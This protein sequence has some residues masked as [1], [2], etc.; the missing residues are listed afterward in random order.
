MILILVVIEL[1]FFILFFRFNNP[2]I[3]FK[4]DAFFI[5]LIVQVFAYTVL[6]PSALAMDFPDILKSEYI[7]NI[8]FSF[9]FFIIPLCL[10]YA[11]LR[12]VRFN[13][14]NI[15]V[16]SKNAQLTEGARIKNLFP[17]C[18]VWL[19]FEGMYLYF[20]CKNHLFY[21]RVGTEVIAQRLA[22]IPHV[23]LF[24]IRSVELIA[25]PVIALLWI[26]L[27]KTRL[28]ISLSALQKKIVMFTL[29]VSFFAYAMTSLLNSRALF[30]ELFIFM[31]L[32]YFTFKSINL[33]KF[34]KQGIILLL[35]IVYLIFIIANLRVYDK[36]KDS[37]LDL[38]NV[39]YSFKKS[40]ES[41]AKLQWLS[42]MDCM[43]LITK[44]QPALENS[45]YAY[46]EAW[47]T[48]FLIAVGQF[49]SPSLVHQAKSQA[50]T[51]AKVYL[52]E[53]YTQ[54][55]SKD[56]QS[57]SLTDVY[58]NF[59]Y[60]GFVFAAIFFAFTFAILRYIL[61]NTNSLRVIFLGLILAVHLLIFE[62][63]FISYLI[64][65]IRYVPIACILLLLI[66]KKVKSIPVSKDVRDA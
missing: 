27:F 31:T 14:G 7:Q 18:M 6:F 36:A 55:V 26:A 54:I 44:M 30:A 48:P 5:L 59:G 10:F 40:S 22:N 12:K 17:L 51:T 56:Y 8:L 53:N 41:D 28:N 20:L 35:F 33:R 42:R 65:W 21:R 34:Y 62:Q 50:V 47:Q 25:I 2:S 3:S 23:D 45:G 15:S 64:G 52:M 63:E 66:P 9:I 32:I 24:F 11:F 58:G 57:C 43:D 38:L 1:L 60:I 39:T 19:L 46:G 13:L 49:I 4:N 29:V 37:W 61:L 16:L